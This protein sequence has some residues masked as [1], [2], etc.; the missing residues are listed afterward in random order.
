[1]IPRPPK[2]T[3]TD[4]LLPYTARFRSP[5]REAPKAL[6]GLHRRQG[7]RCQPRQ[8]AGPAGLGIGPAI[9]WHGRCPEGDRRPIADGPT[10]S[11][12]PGGDLRPLE[13]ISLREVP[14]DVGGPDSRCHGSSTPFK[15]IFEGTMNKVDD[16]SN[17][18]R[19]DG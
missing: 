4:T 9:P 2:T 6:G 10:E 11:R 14:G 1:M 17:N 7:R 19:A 18:K 8:V 16:M 3:R 5:G 13:R 15:G 12:A